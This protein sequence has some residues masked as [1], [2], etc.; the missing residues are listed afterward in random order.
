MRAFLTT[1]LFYGCLALCTQF[2]SAVINEV[3]ALDSK[4]L[5]EVKMASF[6]AWGGLAAIVNYRSNFAAYKIAAYTIK[7]LSHDVLTRTLLYS[8]V[9]ISVEFLWTALFD[10]VTGVQL[11]NL[12]LVG[13][14]SAWMLFV[15]GCGILLFEITLE[16]LQLLKSNWL[17]RGSFYALSC[18]CWEALTGGL[19]YGLVGVIPWDYRL[20][21]YAYTVYGLINLWYFPAWFGFGFLLERLTPWLKK[22]AGG[23]CVQC[24]CVTAQ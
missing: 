4:L 8:L 1:F 17:V 23:V 10:L 22:G 16:K 2:F 15:Y 9:G 14:S 6:L 19:I 18:F 24:K 7:T 21:P 13:Y 11:L 20:S 5:A 12:S 3:N